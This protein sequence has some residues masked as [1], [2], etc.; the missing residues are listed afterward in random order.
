[1]PMLEFAVTGPD[2]AQ[3]A[4]ALEAILEKILSIRPERRPAPTEKKSDEKALNA[5]TV[6][7]ATMILAIPPAILAT[8]DL[9]ERITKRPKAEEIITQA[10]QITVNG[11]VSITVT[12]NGSAVPVPLQS[13]TADKLLELVNKA[14]PVAHKK[15]SHPR[16]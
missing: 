6:A 10:K 8:V 3:A 7:I 2:A 12:I 14:G 11:N 13:L 9:A 1:M 5:V 4:D 16:K 15:P